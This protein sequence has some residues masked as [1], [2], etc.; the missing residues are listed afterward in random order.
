MQFYGD[1][2]FGS[3]SGR[4]QGIGY[5]MELE[6]RLRSTLIHSSDTSVNYTLDD[7]TDLFPFGQPLY[8]DMSHDR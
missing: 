1:Y 6:A 2:G 7:N 8:F 3:P 4:A 5:V